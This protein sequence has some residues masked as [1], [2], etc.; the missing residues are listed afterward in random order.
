[1]IIAAKKGLV[2]VFQVLLGLGANVY[3]KDVDI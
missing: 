1:L 2:A 3:Q